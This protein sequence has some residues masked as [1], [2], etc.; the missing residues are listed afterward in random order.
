MSVLFNHG[1]KTISSRRL[2]SD[3]NETEAG[4]VSREEIEG[5]YKTVVVSGAGALAVWGIYSIILA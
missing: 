2:D 5:R 3:Q 1:H 4:Y